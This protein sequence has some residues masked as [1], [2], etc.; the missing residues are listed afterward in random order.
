MRQHLFRDVGGL[1]YVWG[2][3]SRTS[4]KDR[5][6]GKLI[7]E[8]NRHLLQR[9]TRKGER[10]RAELLADSISTHRGGQNT[11]RKMLRC[12]APGLAQNYPRWTR[13]ITLCASAAGQT[14]PTQPDARSQDHLVP[15]TA[16][17]RLI[18][19]SDACCVSR[20]KGVAP[21]RP[22]TNTKL[23]RDA[24]C[25]GL[26]PP[27]SGICFSRA[28][29]KPLAAPVLKSPL[30]LASRPYR[31]PRALGARARDQH[32]VTASRCAPRKAMIYWA[33]WPG[34]DLFFCL[35][36]VIS[37]ALVGHYLWCAHVLVNSYVASRVRACARR[38]AARLQRLVGISSGRVLSVSMGMCAST[39][40]YASRTP[41]ASRACTQN[42]RSRVVQR[43]A[44]AAVALAREVHGVGA[45][46]RDRGI[47]AVR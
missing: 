47:A 11:H 24:R 45:V 17:E 36:G 37:G 18:S 29:L 7:D 39:G 30:H 27:Q 46:L 44:R 8:L 15:S 2:V 9:E 32:R 28:C 1:W 38:L 40:M 12:G 3:F 21:A 31:V 35:F 5:D 25:F 10:Q 33:W 4:V 43:V 20:K 14:M 42:H 34:W 6:T 22:A 19:L 41:T 26:V 13:K 16:P 23:E